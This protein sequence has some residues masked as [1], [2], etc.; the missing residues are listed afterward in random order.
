[1]ELWI[2]LIGLF[3]VSYNGLFCGELPRAVVLNEIK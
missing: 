3:G 1:M 2:D